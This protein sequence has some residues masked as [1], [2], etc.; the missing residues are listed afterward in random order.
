MS[1]FLGLY[2]RPAERCGGVLFA[3]IFPR[4]RMRPPDPRRMTTV[5]VGVGAVVLGVAAGYVTGVLR[6]GR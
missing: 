1:V 5:V 2:G 3:R 4:P 6:L